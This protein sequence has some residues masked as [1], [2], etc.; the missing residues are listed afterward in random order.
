MISLLIGFSLIFSANAATVDCKMAFRVESSHDLS[1]LYWMQAAGDRYV[2][3]TA[4]WGDSSQIYDLVLNKSVPVIADADIYPLPDGETVIY[5]EPLRFYRFKD[6]QKD[7]LNSKSKPKPFFESK[8]Q[9]GYY[10]SAGILKDSGGKQVVRVLTAWG[11]GLLRDY[12]ITKSSD[13]FTAKPLSAKPTEICRNISKDQI[14]NEIPILS[15]DGKMLATRDNK[16]QTTKIFSIQMPTGNC[17]EIAD[18]GVS[19][20]KVSFSFDN[21]NVAYRTDHMTN[22]EPSA[23]RIHEFNLETKK[24]RLISTPLEHAAGAFAHRPDGT[25][26]YD[27]KVNVSKGKQ[28]LVVVDPRQ[29]PELS[30]SL[31]RKAEAVGS[32]WASACNRPNLSREDLV[33]IGARLNASECSKILI[34][35]SYSKLSDDLRKDSLESLFE[36]CKNSKSNDESNARG[37]R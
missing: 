22:G 18:L 30:S 37:V 2:T 35:D 23:S 34:E 32:L 13:G 4:P 19:T 8:E 24:D 17:K 31:G 20:T 25:L 10:Q 16:T 1:G 15:R 21:R 36:F 14:D 28:S 11:K 3:F 9:A 5:P 33:T 29:I 12:E 26:M 7:L 27:S 6:L